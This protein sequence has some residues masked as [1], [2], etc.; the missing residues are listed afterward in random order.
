MNLLKAKH[1]GLVLL[2]YIVFMTI[3]L[4]LL[5]RVV[6]RRLDLP[7]LLL[8]DDDYYGIAGKVVMEGGRLDG[9]SV[10]PGV[11]LL[12]SIIYFFPNSMHHMIR[13]YLAV[14]CN[15]LTLLLLFLIV[16][17]L[18]KD[19]RIYFLAS[20]IFCLHPIA[21]HWT[22]KSMPEPVI[23]LL[24]MLFIYL[25]VQN[26]LKYWGIAA[27][28]FFAS[29]FFRPTVLLVPIP[30]VALALFQR[31]CKLA[32]FG[33]FLVLLSISGYWINNRISSPA[34]IDR[35]VDYSSGVH[36]VVMDAFFVNAVIKSR[37]FNTGAYDAVK[38]NRSIADMNYYRWLV[39][40]NTNNS[41]NACELLVQ[42]IRQNPKLMIK[43]LALNPIF[44]FSLSATTKESLLNFV[45]NLVLLILA[46]WGLSRVEISKSE[47]LILAMLVGY[48]LIFWLCHGYSRYAYGLLPLLSYFASLGFFKAERLIKG[49]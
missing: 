32:V 22:I 45:I 29:I 21:L 25:V 44:L 38:G 39:N 8:M 23:T 27:L 4:F 18:G 48:F 30:I 7:T 41:K 9:H 37:H 6:D 33:F 11:P 46:I 43:K 15:S 10:G 24:F 40:N 16:K 26:K 5:A 36:E 31:T 3:I 35:A 12:Y 13:Y 34:P 14:A 20:L 1:L 28:V 17:K 47:Q 19:S 42:F 2:G 49:E